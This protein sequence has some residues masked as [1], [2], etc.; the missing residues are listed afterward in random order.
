[1]RISPT[2]GSLHKTAQHRDIKTNIHTV[3][4]IRNHDLSDQ[5]IKSCASD[6]AATRTGYHLL[7]SRKPLELKQR[8]F[9]RFK[10]NVNREKWMDT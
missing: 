4:G 8:L 7:I 9:R 5:A 10:K 2:Q 6:G 3:S 1:M